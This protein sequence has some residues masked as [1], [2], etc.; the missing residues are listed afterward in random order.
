MAWV[1]LA[2][3]PDLVDI[4]ELTAANPLEIPPTVPSK[5]SL[6]HADP[7][8]SPGYRDTDQDPDLVSKNRLENHIK[9]NHNYNGIIIF[10]KGITLFCWAK[11]IVNEY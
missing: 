5:R 6:S 3:T 4:R 7:I 11:N 8:G 9:I 1:S 2:F 10:F